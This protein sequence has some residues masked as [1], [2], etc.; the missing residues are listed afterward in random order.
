MK[1]HTKSQIIIWIVNLI[2][3]IIVKGLYTCDCSVK[4]PFFQKTIC[5]A[6]NKNTENISYSKM[7]PLWFFFCFL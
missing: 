2:N 1:D 6:T 5:N 7:Y 4:N 3:Y